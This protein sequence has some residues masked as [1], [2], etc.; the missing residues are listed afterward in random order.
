[1]GA[2]FFACRVRRAKGGAALAAATALVATLLTASPARA[3]LYIPWSSY[4]PGWTDTYVPTSANDCVAGRSTCVNATLK[5]LNRI[6]TSTG[7]S[8]SH[9]APFALAYLRMTQTYK[10]SR[11]QAGYYQDVP[12]ANHQDAVF[13]KYFTDSYYNYYG[14]NRTAVPQAWKYAFQAADSETLT[15]AGDLLMGINRDLPFVLASVG[16]VAPD[17]SSRK[18]DYDKVEDWLYADTAPLMDE[19]SQR[20]DPTVNDDADPLGLSYSALFQMVSLWRENAW[21]NAE[22]LITA[23]TPEERAQVSQQIESYANSVAQG[24]LVSQANT[25]VP[26]VGGV[27]NGLTGNTTSRDDYCAAHNGDA[28]PTAYPMGWPSPYG[29]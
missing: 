8:C 23:A 18:P 9:D 6:L 7:R 3:G 24:L 14:G 26:L 19:I 10:W 16:L 27:L 28:T 21:R 25:D 12:F 5:E 20:F 13:A 2:K 4:L 11:D 17:G 15:G 22:R 1:M 29:A